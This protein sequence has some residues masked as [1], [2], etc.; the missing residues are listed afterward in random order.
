MNKLFEQLMKKRGITEEF[1][2]PKYED[3]ADPFTLPDMEPAVERIVQAVKNQHHILIYGDYDVDGVTASTVMADALR[4]AGIKKIDIMLPDR[5]ADGYGMSPKIIKRVKDL[6]A[7]LVITV[8]CGSSNQAIIEE[9]TTLGVDTIVT[10]HHE[11]STDL[12]DAVAVINPKR[13]DYD[14]FRDL[15][16]VGVAFKLAQALVKKGLIK[17]GQEKWLLD[18]VLIGTICDNMPL[19]KENRILSF[20]GMK[21]LAKTRRAGLKELMAKAG[22]KTLNT[23]AIGFQIGPRLNA[24]GRLDSAELSLNLLMADK[25]INAA[26]IADKLENLNKKRK[27]E[28]QAALD[29]IKKRG[30]SD[31]PVIIET[32][33]WH[34]GILGIVAGK[35]VEEYHRPSFVLS[36]VQEGVFK[37]S[38]RSFGEFNLASALTACKDYIINGGGHALAAGV[39]VSSDNLYGFRE[40]MVDYYQS[41]NLKDQERFLNLQDDLAVDDL[42]NMNLDLLDDLMLLEPFGGDNEEPVFKLQDFRVAEV[43]LMGAERQHLALI[44][45]DKNFRQIKLLAFFAPDEWRQIAIDARLDVWVK[46]LE[47][48][49]NGMRTIEGRILNL[50]YT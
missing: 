2:R 3:L 44:V 14:G 33:N 7:E 24:A 38:G 10:D 48:D 25:K 50:K 31:A 1:L 15:A 30:V 45:E 21:V 16:G 41:L 36:E 37:G 35:L 5:F 26:A 19:V 13:K 34:E 18:L 22:V 8:D 9:L 29:E 20:Y 32:G 46:L 39:K 12:P 49:W 43:R 47:N 4:L 28:Q 27:T 6:K 17:E 40:K 11:I 23:D 42:A